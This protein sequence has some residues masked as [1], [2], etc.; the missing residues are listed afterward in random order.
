MA[1]MRSKAG[2]NAEDAA[3]HEILRFFDTGGNPD[4]LAQAIR[5]WQGAIFGLTV[6]STGWEDK[7]NPN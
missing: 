7:T 1:N 3:K 6:G 2:L 4:Q 5:D